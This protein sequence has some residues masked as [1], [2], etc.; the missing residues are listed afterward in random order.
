[1]TFI[2]SAF[3]EFTAS[4]LELLKVTPPTEESI[5][6]ANRVGEMMGKYAWPGD[7]VRQSVDYEAGR[8]G[9]PSEV[10]QR[11]GKLAYDVMQ[12]TYNNP[13]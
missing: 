3:K 1:M 4:D 6:L 5:A 11:I 13:A 2:T 7:M 9:W 8:L 10:A 12:Q